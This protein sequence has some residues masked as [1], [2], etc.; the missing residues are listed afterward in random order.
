ML[1]KVNAFFLKD[2]SSLKTL[3]QRVLQ[4]I[5][6]LD[7]VA[8]FLFGQV[9]FSIM[10]HIELAQTLVVILFS[11][12]L[13]LDASQRELLL[14]IKRGSGLEDKSGKCLGSIATG[15]ARGPAKSFRPADFIESKT[16][17]SSTQVPDSRRSFV[18]AA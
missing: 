6:I 9:S 18:M 10:F 15:F 8:Q 11:G 12:L 1:S 13:I 7:L 5:H 3:F 17:S 16:P 14:I 2:A 4:L